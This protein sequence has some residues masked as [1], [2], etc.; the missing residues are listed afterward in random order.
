MLTRNALVLIFIL[1]LLAI[2][3]AWSEL[4]YPDG[5]GHE[6]ARGGLDEPP[7]FGQQEPGR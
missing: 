6:P 4:H 7:A 5:E 1:V 2:V 3:A